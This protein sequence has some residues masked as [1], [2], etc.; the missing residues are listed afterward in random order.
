[1]VRLVR[2]QRR[3][4]GRAPAAWPPTRSSSPTRPP[5][6]R[7]SPGS[8]RAT[9]TSARSSVVGAACGAVA[10]LVAITPASGFVTAGGA[11]VIG[12]V[13]GGLCYSATLLRARSKVD[14]ALDV[15]AVHGVGGM[16]G[17]IA[18][19]VFATA[20]VQE[21]YTGLIDGNAGQVGI[22]L[23]AV[24]ASSPTRSSPRSSSSSS[25]TLIL[26]IRV[27]R[28]GG[29]GPRPRPPRR[30]R[31]PGL[32]AAGAALGPLGA[33]G[34]GAAPPPSTPGRRVRRRPVPRRVRA[35]RPAR[36]RTGCPRG[37]ILEPE[38]AAHRPG[39]VARR[40][41][42]D[43]GAAR[44]VVAPDERLE[45]PI[46]P[47]AGM[48]GPSSVTASNTRPPSRQ[49]RISIRP[50]SR[51]V[52]GAVLEQVFEQP[53]EQVGR[54]DRRERPLGERDVELV[55]A[56]DRG[57]RGHRRLG[58]GRDVGRPSDGR[59]LART[60]RPA[61]IE[62]TIPS[63]RSTWRSAS[64]CQRRCLAPPVAG[65][66]PMSSRRARTTASGVRSSWVTIVASRA[67]ASSIARRLSPGPR[68]R[69]GGGPSRRSRRA[70]PRASRGSGHRPR[71]TRGA[72]PSGR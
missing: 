42:A 25:S 2:L 37:P 57:Q 72:R 43:P 70:G 22:Q 36:G 33:P 52:L 50:P 65:L 12:L 59:V 11:L 19:G 1:M 26:G 64:S 10:G 28:A 14:D 38:L 69:A 23:V 47:S 55:A 5:P 9:S 53:P 40:E 45:D 13:A 66:R 39:E 67:R 62:S 49:P 63:S 4:G 31:L 18:T 32:R 35:R 3:I 56:E 68:P 24:V 61:R 16:F 15:F 44:G 27:P 41:Q 17:A 48:P 30:G 46:P 34:A 20:A 51:G 7:P 58:H 60:R 71:G 6:R 8:G 29:D 21:A 54:G